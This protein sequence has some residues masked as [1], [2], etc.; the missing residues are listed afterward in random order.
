MPLRS[1]GAYS[2]AMPTT[3]LKKFFDELGKAPLPTTK[4]VAEMHQL[5]E[6]HAKYDMEMLGPP[7]LP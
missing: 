5:H 2:S 3:D 7:I 1:S 4:D 6:L